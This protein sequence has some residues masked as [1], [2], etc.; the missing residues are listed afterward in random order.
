MTH[1]ERRGSVRVPARL[2]ME[3]AV[4]GGTTS[5]ESL[6]VSAN[7]VYFATR[8]FIPV[9]T[10]LRITL[11][12]A[13]EGKGAR[14]TSVACDG[15]V[16]R[17]EPEFEDPAVDEYSVA[18]YFTSISERDREALETYILKHVPF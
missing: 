3:I 11:D 2:A 12:L 8:Y 10:R 16:V 17:T 7:G 15:V 4:H 5:V 6:N 9:L 1:V 18:C 14:S 13:G